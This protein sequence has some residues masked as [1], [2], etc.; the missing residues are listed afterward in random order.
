[1]LGRIDFGV[2][3]GN[4]TLNGQRARVWKKLSGLELF[5]YC[6]SNPPYQMETKTNSDSSTAVKNIFQEFQEAGF[7][8]SSKTAMIYPGGRWFQQSGK[9]LKDFGKNLINNE[10]L[11]SVDLYDKNESKEFFPA[12]ALT[13]G[14]SIVLLDKSFKNNGHITINGE[15]VSAPGDNILPMKVEYISLVDKIRK[16]NSKFIKDSVSSRTLFSIESNEVETNPSDFISVK[17]SPLPPPSMKNPI[18]VLTN[19]KSGKAGRPEW[20]WM[21]KE[22]VKT[23]VDKID[24]WKFTIKSAQFAH[25]TTQLEKGVIVGS[26]EV[27]GRAKVTIADFGTKDEVLN[28]EK[29]MK[30][31]FS[32]K[33]YLQSVSG[34]LTNICSFV[35]DVGDYT[36]NNPLFADD[37][38]LPIGHEY[39][40]LSLEDRLFKKFNLS[41][42]EISLIKE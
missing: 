12:A 7:N 33:L 41:D 19:N 20:F 42:E 16:T 15:K 4:E 9:G 24:R 38:S 21:E 36:S 29:Y 40:N 3:K 5:D 37:N 13:D 22:K 28:F 10:N 17:N 34:G 6:V 30:T 35:P 18:K 11:K 39:K 23:G 2:L 31:D 26:G 32:K 1:M 25:E 8:I 27:H 14:T